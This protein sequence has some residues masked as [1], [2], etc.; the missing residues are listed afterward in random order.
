[1]GLQSS[2]RATPELATFMKQQNE[3]NLAHAH[4]QKAKDSA[5]K[6]HYSLH[7]PS[8]DVSKEHL[9]KQL[10]SG[11]TESSYFP[12]YSIAFAKRFSSYPRE[13]KIPG[14][15]QSGGHKEREE[16]ATTK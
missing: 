15:H 7:P 14:I 4:Q 12:N 1:M 16:V 11:S 8:P 5:F 9:T 13:R 2:R 3:P 10:F 6:L